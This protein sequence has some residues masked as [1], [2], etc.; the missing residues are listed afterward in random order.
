M[1]TKILLA[2]E[3]GRYLGSGIDVVAN[4]VN[5][6]LCV[7]AEPIALLDYLATDRIDEAVL[8]QLAEGMHAG[9][10]EAGIAIPGGEIA[11]IG[12][13]LADPGTGGPMLD[14][15]GTARGARPAGDGP[16]GW[17][18]PLDGS[19]VQPGDAIIGLPSSGLH[20]NG[21]S[22]ARSVLARG[23]A[24]LDDPVP[25]TGEPLASQLLAPTRIYVR[26][27]GELWAA[28]IV[29]H[30]LAHI[31]G[32]G[33]LNLARLAADVSYQLDRFP[34]PAPVFAFLQRLG[35]VADATMFETFN[36][37]I[38]MCIVVS[39]AD[40]SAAVAALAR[41]SAGAGAAVIGSV[42]AK[43]GRAVVIPAAGLHGPGDPFAHLST[44]R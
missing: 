36:M 26:A 40:A 10:A 28:G 7:G 32:G 1:G 17:R 39:E 16:G 44:A 29:P 18:E 34:D 42:T 37:G 22:L 14:L 3:T 8:G 20:S 23:G 25:G 13:M 35:G 4:N 31:S 5:D 24:R 19:A 9:A 27:V 6:L 11:Q 43:P 21:F 12:A 38:G 41:S 2:R 30:G 33:M 15:G